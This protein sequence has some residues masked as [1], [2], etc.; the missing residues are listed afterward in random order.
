MPNIE[1]PWWDTE[2]QQLRYVTLPDHSIQVL[3]PT[4]ESSRVSMDLWFWFSVGLNVGLVILFAWWWKITDDSVPTRQE[5][6]SK[7]ESVNL[8]KAGRNL[9]QACEKNDPNE[10]QTALLA[11]AT[12]RWPNHLM[13]NIG[14]VAEQ[15]ENREIQT[16]LNDL[17]KV[18]YAKQQIPWDGQRFWK[19]I[20]KY[21]SNTPGKSRQV[22]TSRPP[23]YSSR[24]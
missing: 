10:A 21:I 18:L 7:P 4:T 1:I 19:V 24:L 17:D 8:T 5:T 12:A 2:N 15:L 9:K 20:A 3:S 6:D 14:N 23:L 16:V 13:T 11:W 22:K